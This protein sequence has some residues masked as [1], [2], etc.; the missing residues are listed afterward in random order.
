MAD[1]KETVV[2]TP[3]KEV[4]KGSEI[5]RKS[6]AGEEIVTA[7]LTAGLSELGGRE[8]DD[9]TVA[10]KDGEKVTGKEVEFDEKE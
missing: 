3:D 7:V 1:K 8:G 5:D 10:T 6:H 2:V 9:V 4:A